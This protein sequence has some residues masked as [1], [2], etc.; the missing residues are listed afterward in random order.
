MILKKKIVLISIKKNLK[1]SDIENLGAELHK[2]IDSKKNDEYFV[3]SDSVVGKNE[4]FL[5]NF[6]KMKKTKLDERITKKH[7]IGAI[8]EEQTHPKEYYSKLWGSMYA[9]LIRHLPVDAELPFPDNLPF[10]PAMIKK[11]IVSCAD[12]LGE[13]LAGLDLDYYT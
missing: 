5:G 7:D 8:C 3:V 12:Y 13:K 10:P 11:I 4:N 9:E 1:N 2:K 6:S